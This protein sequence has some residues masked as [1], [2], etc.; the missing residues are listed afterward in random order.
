[1][2]ILLLGNGF[3]LHHKFPT[4]YIDFLYTVKFLA[5]NYDKS[6]DTVAKVF[7]DDR[8]K[9]KLKSICDSFAEHESSYKDIRLDSD[10][11]KLLIKKAKNNI[12]FKYLSIAVDKELT[13]IDFEL[14]I[15]N[16]IDAFNDFFANNDL[17][18]DSFDYEND[19]ESRYIISLFDYFY[20]DGHS[21]RFKQ[22]KDEYTIEK[23]IGSKIV[24]IDKSKIIKELYASLCELADMLKIYLQVFVDSLS[25]EIKKSYQIKNPSYPT[26][27][28]VCTFN[29]TNTYELLYNSIAKV[30]HVHGN[31]KKD[32]V[33]GINPDKFDDLGTIDTLFIQFKKYF[34]RVFFGTDLEF[35]DMIYDLEY[36][37]TKINKDNVSLYVAGHSLDKTDEDIIQS[38]FKYANKIV[39]FYHANNVVGD[40][41]NNLVTIYGKKGFDELRQHSE[42]RFLPHEQVERCPYDQL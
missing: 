40:Y 7:G 26:F 11:I 14:Q 32:V 22:I 29:Y 13:W 24:V 9:G 16:V 5:D 34:Q 10:T 3:D 8:L 39:V 23:L 33:L 19:V 28:Y 37:E 15:A 35:L 36:N 30:F 27:D 25:E 38:L 6:M 12:W 41:I 18:F 2:N 17:Y 1:M 20:Q 4:S 42:L 31:V 21:I